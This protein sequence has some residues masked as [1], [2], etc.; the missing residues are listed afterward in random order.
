MENLSL[1]LTCGAEL[2]VKSFVAKEAVSS[3]FDVEIVAYTPV[4]TLPFEAI[5]GHKASFSIASPWHD[6]TPRTWTGLVRRVEQIDAEPTGATGYKFELV[7]ALWQLSKRVSSRI[8]QHL[9]IVEIATAL[10]AEWEIVP[11][12]RLD[13]TA[14]VKHEYRVQ[15]GETDLAF[16]SRL[17]EEAGIAYTFEDPNAPSEKDPQPWSRLVLCEDATRRDV[18]KTPL[19]YWN[20][21]DLPNDR[22]AV[23]KVRASRE[24]RAGRAT[25]RDFDYRQRPNHKLFATSAATNDA[26]ERIEVFEYLPGGFVVEA[27]PDNARVDERH[28]AS[29]AE[30]ALA[31]ARGGR[32]TVTYQANVIDLAPGAV[33]TMK[34]HPNP[35]LGD[36]RALLSVAQ[37]IEGTRNGEWTATGIATYGDEP[38]R[39][40]R[41]TPKPRVVGV[42]SA[43]VVGPA[44]EEIHTDALGR[45]RVEFPWD[46]EGQMDER[47]S[48]FLRVSQAW[49]GPGYGIVAVPRVGEEVLVSFFEG[50][51]DQPVIVGRVHNGMAPPPSALPGNKTKSIWRTVSSPGGGGYNE[52][53]LDDKKGDELIALRAE[54]DYERLVLREERATIGA[55]LTTKIGASEVHE[56]LND[57]TVKVG[58]S[59][60]ISIAGSDTLSVGEAL[61]IDLGEAGG[62]FSAKEKKIVFTTGEASI[63]LEGPNLYIDAKSI[64]SLKSGDLV[65]LSGGDVKI[66]GQPNVSLN[67]GTA[68]PP[69]I[70]LLNGAQYSLQLQLPPGAPPL[71][72]L[73]SLINMPLLDPGA[74]PGEL[75]IPAE[76][77]AQL[78]ALRNKVMAGLEEIVAKIEN[79]PDILDQI[80]QDVLPEV[81]AAYAAAM[82]RIEQ[83]RKWLEDAKARIAAEIE[84]WKG[85]ILALKARVEAVA[86]EI[87]Q[88]IAA[89]IANVQ[90]KITALRDKA[91]ELIKSVKDSIQQ[92]KD[93]VKSEFEYWKAQAIAFKNKVVGPFE[94]IRKGIKDLTTQ[95]KETVAEFKES[96]TGIVNDVKTTVKDIKETVQNIKNE[97]KDLFGIKSA[98]NDIKNDVKETVE[99]VKEAWNEA[100]D[101]FKDAVDDIKSIFSG[102]DP[103]DGTAMFQGVKQATQAPGGFQTPAGAVGGKG[104]GLQIP[105]AGGAARPGANI[106]PGLPNL[107]K[108]AGR[109]A[110]SGVLHGLTGGA[111]NAA[112]PHLA[113]SATTSAAQKV[114]GG[115]GGGQSGF[116]LERV[117]SEGRGAATQGSSLSQAASSSASQALAGG[118]EA[119][120]SLPRNPLAGS[121][122][123][124]RSA[125][126]TAD[127]VADAVNAAYSSNS[128]VM[129]QSPNEG[130]LLVLRTQK[131]RP[132]RLKISPEHLW[133]LKWTGFKGP[134][135]LPP[136]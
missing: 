67:G 45:V 27:S 83:A 38:H 98:I 7:P 23:T 56:V 31:A 73:A 112:S 121:T 30:K 35:E 43:L 89:A 92:F 4:D 130:Q 111:G 11:D 122:V 118:L 104:G 8:F 77:E 85:E 86:D 79:V 2:T 117:V 29:R 102:S 76:I 95:V 103:D 53:A 99:G 62:T 57:Q 5:V 63:V 26:E 15:Y 64:V 28:A 52:F 133:T 71:D 78:A 1:F 93:K 58:K 25:M 47:S 69:S 6:G 33:F 20:C 39:P 134:T 116:D 135:H 10:L 113:S 22:D 34:G 114:T 36:G 88:K 96:I 105:G 115:I 124:T 110:Q 132:S 50:D 66:D 42:Q 48:C 131:Q 107:T 21:K 87:K 126:F 75:S 72:Q 49:A 3:P 44:G 61:H 129:F 17:L 32:F 12:L 74:A 136:P 94:E 81:E 90:A 127:G 51:P 54:R 119:G 37:R 82:A 40:A 14:F 120:G 41:I 128:P 70:S 18:R 101:G 123:V 106:A 65:S 108:E 19:D 16:L 109:G 13:P 55:S 97:V 100:K 46:R 60:T 9:S 24:V 59:R 84:K 91:R 125:G 68:S 80:G